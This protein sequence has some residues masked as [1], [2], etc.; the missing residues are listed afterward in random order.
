MM[1]RR[2]ESVFGS[3]PKN[4]RK[5]ATTGQAKGK[6]ERVISIRGE[7][8]IAPCWI[9]ILSGTLAP[10]RSLWSN[11]PSQSWQRDA[12]HRPPPITGKGGDF[13]VLQ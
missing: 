8:E 9:P 3:M 2:Q 12:R 5:V 6:K 10:R 13:A 4:P 7:G 11:S 1:G